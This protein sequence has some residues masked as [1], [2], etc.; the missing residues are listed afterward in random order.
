MVQ[1]DLGLK[2]DTEQL[3]CWK[4]GR[5]HSKYFKPEEMFKAICYASKWSPMSNHIIFRRMRTI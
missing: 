5:S 4:F 3:C 2:P 1:V